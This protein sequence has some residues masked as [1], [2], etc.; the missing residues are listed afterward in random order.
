MTLL[1]IDKVRWALHLADEFI[2]RQVSVDFFKVVDE[3]R[4]VFA[5][6]LVVNFFKIKSKFISLLVKTL[7]VELSLYRDL[8]AGRL[9]VSL[10]AFHFL[11]IF[12]N[13]LNVLIQSVFLLR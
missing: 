6:D 8:I 3:T 4:F 5:I 13:L 1:T 2:H 7:D 10:F 11:F 9:E 12:D